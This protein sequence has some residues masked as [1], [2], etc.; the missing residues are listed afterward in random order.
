[1]KN[2]AGIRIPQGISRIRTS[3]E[4][5]KSVYVR[6]A[7]V[8]LSRSGKGYS[9]GKEG[10]VG[11]I[12]EFEV[13]AEIEPV[14]PSVHDLRNIKLHVN[15]SFRERRRSCAVILRRKN[16]ARQRILSFYII[17]Y[18]RVNVNTDAKIYR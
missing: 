14:F 6:Y 17:Y 8:D 1:M 7:A 13:K 15:A 10:A 16:A 18:L 12:R 5:D 9:G 2:R 3:A 4:R 11:G